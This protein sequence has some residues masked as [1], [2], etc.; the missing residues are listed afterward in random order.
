MPLRRTWVAGPPPERPVSTIR[1]VLTS[2]P[3]M[4]FIPVGDLA[5]AQSF[6]AETLGLRVED[7]NP[8]AVILNSGG[9]MLRLTRVEDHHPQPFTIAGWEVPNIGA[10]VDAL[11]SRGFCSLASTAWIRM[12]GAS[13]PRLV[14]ITSPGLRTPTATHSRS[15]HSL[16]RGA[17]DR[18]QWEHPIWDGALCRNPL[19]AG[20]KR[21]GLRIRNGLSRVV[22]VLSIGSADGPVA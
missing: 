2:S 9:T 13:G 12:S 18:Q 6:Y 14:A 7:E 11:V 1:A 20:Y 21:T 16:G 4:A 19:G 17:S 15:P 5:T 8:F 10:T 22:T 3:V